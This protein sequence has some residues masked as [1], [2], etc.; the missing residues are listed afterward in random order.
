MTTVGSTSSST[1]T[2]TSS[3]TT[4]SSSS[5]IDWDALIE[6]AVQAKLDKADTIDLKITANEAKISAYEEVQTLLTTLTTAA[7][8]LRMP[9]GVSNKT[10]DVFQDRTAYLT[11]NGD[12]DASSSLAVTVDDGTTPGSYDFQIL[13]LAK[14]QKVTSDS[15]SS[16]TDDLGYAG[17]FSIGVEDGTSADV[18]VTATMSL[19][20]IAE[21]INN[22]TAT[23]G[24]QATILQVS[25]SE[26][27]LVLTSTDTGETISASSV[28]G[29]DVMASLGVTDDDGAFANELQSAQDAIVKLDGITITR[30]SNDIDDLI[31]G[32]TF[33]LYQVTQ[34]DPDTDSSNSIT[35]DVGADVSSAK[36]AVVAL[37]DAYNAFREFMTAQ[38]AVTSTGTA[39]D[40]AV[41][42]GDGTL[43]NISVA[44]YGALGQ[45][46]DSTSMALLG[47]TFDSDGTLV[48]DE[49][50]LDDALLNNLDTVKAV[51]GYQMTA[52]SSDV[53]LLSRGVSVPSD[54]T[55]DVTVDSSGALSSASVGG[56]SSLFTVSGSRII[57]A[58]GT[59]YEGL[60]LVYTGS[61]SQSIDIS[62]ST[63][64]AELL[65][66][67]AE[68]ASNTSD[69]S[70][71][72]LI[73]NLEESDTT[74]QSKS[75][76]IRDAAATY[77]TNL[78]SRYAKY[79]AAI[80]SAE[81]M[82]DYLTA[83]VDQWNS[84][85]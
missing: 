15:V 79:Q 73:D 37:Q 29:D 28:S 62:L 84:S 85:S 64:I 21:A 65:Y 10:V 75:D 71:Q 5:S 23:S 43:R 83:L 3:A 38:Q 50:T 19:T 2:S 51:L 25:S 55:L 4:L 54:F 76:D 31:D 9:S 27:K 32:V 63:G 82:Q 77:Q 46:V 69:G 80:E 68:A 66:N 41:L 39:S 17:V 47:L 67:S 57:G 52:S 12:V 30:S 74:L 70:L 56:D 6:A 20:E 35:V 13:Q 78:T 34:S 59:A 1:T 44:V 16:K 72:T 81:A 14:A 33:H 18:T 26:Y 48:L 45:T 58:T 36:A 60:S 24:V 8:A 40:D 11:A 7:N 61:T 42:F 49:D 22:T 53:Q